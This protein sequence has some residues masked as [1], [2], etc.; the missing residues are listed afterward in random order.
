MLRRSDSLDCYRDTA[1]CWHAVPAALLTLLM[2][3]QGCARDGDGTQ[4]DTVPTPASRVYQNVLWDTV[5]HLGGQL[6]DSVLLLPRLMA[7]GAGLL[8]V[9]DY[10]DR[11][12]K[13]FDHA[14]S[15]LWQY[16]KTGEGPGEFLN[17]FDI[18]VAPDGD[19]SVY[20]TGT[21]RITILS[22][23]GNVRDMFTPGIAGRDVIPIQNMTLVT[24]VRPGNEYWIG[25][26]GEGRQLASGRFPLDE[27]ADAAHLARQTWSVSGGRG[28]RWATIFP[29]GNIILIHDGTELRCHGRLVEGDPFPAAAGPDMPVWAIA[30][31]LTDSTLLVLA[32][33]TT[34]DAMAII[35]EYSTVDCSYQRTIPLPRKVRA[36]AFDGDILF[37][38]YEDPAPAILAVRLKSAN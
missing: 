31:A 26:D 21:G 36:L 10:G 33:G 27:L 23:D 38:A 7:S 13:A 17:P 28:P 34:S 12:I 22:P 16:G 24:P 14:G 29:N 19:V 32:R 4:Q 2:T 15:L 35:D 11:Q 30:A 20:D 25:F 37:L 9:Y 18:D 3:I 6:E 1:P 8:F 5:F